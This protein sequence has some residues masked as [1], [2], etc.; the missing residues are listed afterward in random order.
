MLYQG[1]LNGGEEL[2]PFAFEDIGIELSPG[3]PQGQNAE[4]QCGQSVYR[5]SH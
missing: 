5:L 3:L 2:L 4:P 1:G